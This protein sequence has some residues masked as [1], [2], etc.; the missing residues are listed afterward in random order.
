MKDNILLILRAWFNTFIMLMLP[1]CILLGGYSLFVLYY[2]M[3]LVPLNVFIL[4]FLRFG[5][6]FK[7][8][9]QSL[10]QLVTEC[11][12]FLLIV[13]SCI[14]ILGSC[15]YVLKDD[16]YSLLVFAACIAG[17]LLSVYV[18][19]RIIAIYH[20]QIIEWGNTMTWH[21]KDLSTPNAASV[22]LGLSLISLQLFL[23]PPLS[24][25]TWVWCYIIEAALIILAIISSIKRWKC[26]I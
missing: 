17:V 15:G 7:Y 5:L 23:F 9:F 8:I 14:F 4:V 18:I 1:S 22:F 25:N 12:L 11:A 16:T 6:K 26:A 3:F 2:S 10:K 24:G 20:P 19:I 21:D 13:M